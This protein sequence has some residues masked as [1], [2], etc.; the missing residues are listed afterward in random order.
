MLDR[1]LARREDLHGW[2]QP[3]PLG[4]E[5]PSPAHETRDRQP[6]GDYRSCDRERC[7]Q[8]EPKR[9]E[10]AADDECRDRQR[11]RLAARHAPAAERYDANGHTD[12]MG[13]G[14]A[15][16][17][18]RSLARRFSGSPVSRYTVQSLI[19]RAPRLS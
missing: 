3:L 12:K 13:D 5:A 6:R 2:V 11:D 10:H 19:A 7:E 15:L 16:R 9:E 14:P 17:Y 18:Y 4:R 1:G 8:C